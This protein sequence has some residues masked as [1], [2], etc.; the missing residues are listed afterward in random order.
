MLVE[1]SF[2]HQIEVQDRWRLTHSCNSIRTCFIWIWQEKAGV[3]HCF[4]MLRVLGELQVEND[5]RFL[6]RLFDRR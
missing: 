4:I 6:Y 3:T 1:K 5:S 2:Y